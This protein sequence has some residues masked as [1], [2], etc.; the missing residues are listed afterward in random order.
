MESLRSLRELEAEYE[1]TRQEPRVA[2]LRM[3]KEKPARTIADV[4]QSLGHSERSLQRWWGIYQKKGITALLDI[5][6]A[7]GKRPRRLDENKLQSLRQ[8]VQSDGFRE[9]KEVREWLSQQHGIDY[10]PSGISYLMRKTLKAQPSGWMMFDDDPETKRDRGGRPGQAAGVPKH[11]VRFLNAM[12]TSSDGRTWG[13]AFREALREVLGDVDR[14]SINVNVECNLV[15]PE[16]YQAGTIITQHVSQ[17]RTTDGT[18]TITPEQRENPHFERVLDGMRSQGFPFKLFHPPCAFDY[19]YKGHAY[20]GTL[21]LWREVGV[22]PI[23]AETLET[24]AELEPFLNFALS[25]L[26]ARYQSEKPIDRVFYEALGD[27]FADAGLSPQ[28]QRIVTLQMMGHSYK[29]M[30]DMLSIAVDTIKKHF[31]QIHRKTGTRGQ[32]ELFGKYFSSRLNTE[33]PDT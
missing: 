27:M 5:G 33:Q 12:P 8:K 14:I 2:M 19:Y 3:L 4:G 18:V 32:A 11:I 10:S 24:M 1:G 26:V 6:R 20:L 22:S 29:E 30:A 28:E 7:G 13:N 21:I 25:D 9:L 31:K 23:S 16:G 15:N 17:S